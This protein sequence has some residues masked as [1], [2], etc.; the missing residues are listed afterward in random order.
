MLFLIKKAK[1]I[2]TTVFVLYV[3]SY[4]AGYLAGKQHW[5]EYRELLNSDVGTLSRSL[6]TYVPGYGDL[7]EEY[8]SWH[9]E[10]RNKF[11][12]SRNHW[13]MRGLIFLNNWIAANITM[14]IRAVFV[15]P[16][17]LSVFGKFAQG[18]VF[19]QTPA[20]T[21]IWIT[22]LMEFGGYFL[23]ICATLSMVFWTIF[24]RGFGFV[25]RWAA[26][27]GGLKLLGVA[28]LVSAAAM[29][30]GSIVET[31]FIMNMFGKFQ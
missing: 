21:H 7:I 27:R 29:I 6:E 14:I 15:L 1:W 12:F 8:R 10:L 22:F 20:S 9:D 16:I 31:D 13:G 19:A 28:Y 18:V 17:S 25:T 11:L 30:I 24:Y 3:L 23:V 2:Y 4:G 5:V 26:F